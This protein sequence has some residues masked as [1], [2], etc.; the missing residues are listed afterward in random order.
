[1]TREPSSDVN[2][3][4]A[5]RADG[6]LPVARSVDGAFADPLFS[7]AQIG[8]ATVFGSLFGGAL[9]LQ[10]NYRAMGRGRAAAVAM[11]IGV[12]VTAGIVA[13]ART[14][15][16]LPQLGVSLVAIITFGVVV[17]VLQRAVYEQHVLAG[18]PR[19]SSWWVLAAI[20]ASA[21]TRY[22]AVTVIA[23]IVRLVARP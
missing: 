17:G 1:M 21:V 15:P 16:G 4:A 12:V 7:T 19:R 9:L 14:Y 23:R 18:G 22:A 2:P 20:A 11:A 13:L 6:E 5:P 3:Y 10:A 8:W